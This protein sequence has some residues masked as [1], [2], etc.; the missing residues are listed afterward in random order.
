MNM[1]TGDGDRTATGRHTS[2]VPI[3][4]SG[5]APSGDHLVI[6]GHLIVHRHGQIEE[7]SERRIDRGGIR[8][9]SNVGTARDV[10]HERG[11]KQLREDTSVAGGQNLVVVTAYQRLVLRQIHRHDRSDFFVV[12]R[13]R[14][15]I[16]ATS[17]KPSSGGMLSDDQGGGA[18][19]WPEHR[20]GKPAG[21]WAPRR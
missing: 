5:S 3:V 16:R 11:I 8:F 17:R 7:G 21:T 9:G 12:M 20:D 15:F 2:E 4:G 14:R 18:V 10:A 6:L 1:D 19:L 13:T